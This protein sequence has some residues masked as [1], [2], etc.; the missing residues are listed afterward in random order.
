M[1]LTA[2]QQRFVEEYLV[3][4]NATQAAVRAGYN[5]KSARATGGEN[6]QKPAVAAAIQS[7]QDALREQNSVTVERVLEELRRLAFSDMGMF[8]TWGPDGVDLIDSANIDHEN[9]ACVAEVSET[10]NAKGGT[11]V[12]FKLHSKTD[13][14]NQLARHLGMFNDR[15]EVNS[16]GGVMLVPTPVNAEEWARAARENQARLAGEK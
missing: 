16:A 13:A 12:R 2:K 5:P 11:T 10:T 3:D 8:A 15:L 1:K 14:L 4:C 6:L 7:A 9:R